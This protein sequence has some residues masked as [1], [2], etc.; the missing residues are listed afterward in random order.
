MNEQNDKSTK[1]WSGE[2]RDNHQQRMLQTNGAAVNEFSWHPKDGHGE[3]NTVERGVRTP[4][5]RSPGGK[6]GYPRSPGCQK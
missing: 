4:Q 5:L 1:R 3:R 2:T 6:T